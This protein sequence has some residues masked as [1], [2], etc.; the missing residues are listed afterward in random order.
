MR[1]PSENLQK[2]EVAA[3]GT[4]LLICENKYLLLLVN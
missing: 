4:G 2:L 1:E 3:I